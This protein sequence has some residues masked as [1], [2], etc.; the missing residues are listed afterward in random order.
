MTY[1]PRVKVLLVRDGFS[2]SEVAALLHSAVDFECVVPA[3][4]ASSGRAAPR[5]VV[6]C[7]PDL[8]Q[9]CA[10][11]LR[12]HSTDARGVTHHDWC[13]SPPVELDAVLK[14]AHRFPATPLLDCVLN[15]GRQPETR[16]R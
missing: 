9:L 4:S 2:D 7:G 12:E 5:I 16:N 13:A 8:R 15:V 6:R 11:V 3:S 14:H 10:V 1:A